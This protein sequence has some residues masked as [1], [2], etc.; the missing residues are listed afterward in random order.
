VASSI[1]SI[2]LIGIVLACHIAWADEEAPSWVKKPPVEDGLNRYYV[3][4]ASGD[5]SERELFN[6][7][8]EDAKNS[9]ITENYGVLTQISKQSY[10]SLESNTAINRVNETSKL[11]V[12]KQFQKTEQYIKGN[13]VWILYKY[14]KSEIAAE[15]K[16]LETKAA[17]DKPIDLSSSELT[18]PIFLACLMGV[19]F[20]LALLLLA[21]D[22]LGGRLFVKFSPS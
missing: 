16:R 20:V 22:F 2:L 9:A 3:G 1:K 21:L 14:P 18:F 15:L 8:Y 5:F 6:Q 12:L 19:E 10:E 17:M 4:R 13:S 11:V 7:A